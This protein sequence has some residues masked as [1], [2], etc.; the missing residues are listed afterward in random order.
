MKDI[1]LTEARKSHIE[2]ILKM[3]IRAFKEGEENHLTIDKTK[4]LSVISEC[5]L[6]PHQLA[7]VAMSEGKIRGLV[8]GH[9]DSHAYCKELVAEDICIYVTTSYRRSQLGTQL[10]ETYINWC[11]RIPK[12]AVSGLAL[13][14]L[15]ETSEGMS[16]LFEKHGYQL[17]GKQYSK[18][19][20]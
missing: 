5:V 16:E 12:L 17:I 18:F 19:N 9:V 10:V 13:S 14:R 11:N 7:V 2:D 3:S 15:N 8:L 20:V 6:S 4:M 1:I